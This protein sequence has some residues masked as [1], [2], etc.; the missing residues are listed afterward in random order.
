MAEWDADVQIDASV[1]AGLIEAQFPELS[2][3]TLV[4]F[5]SGWDNAAWLVNDRWVFRFPR[6]RLGAEVMAV[7]LAHL[8][9]LAP[10]LPLPAPLPVFIGS[11]ASGYPYPFGGYERLEG[12]TADAAALTDANRCA[13][14]A[15][16][17][18]FLRELHGLHVSARERQTVPGDLLRRA[19]PG[20][21]APRVL[22]RLAQLEGHA[23]VESG[24]IQDWIERLRTTPMRTEPPT[25]VHGD[26]YA[27]HLLVDRSARLCGIID[28]G[29]VH[30]GD[31][32]IDLSV[33]FSFVPPQGRDAF[34]GAYGAIDAASW[35][36]ARFRAL[37]YGVL[38]TG[39]GV[40]TD[41]VA[42]SAVG[43]TALRFATA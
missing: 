41:D 2:P 12:V 40:S 19:D 11:P 16:L 7:E 3:V 38:L 43:V 26:L 37:H 25:W 17:G 33:A 31:P 29:D 15:E 39:Y 8:P 42:L 36:R 24:R 35:D 34:R 5:G 20:Y 21:R 30:Q 13:L 27:R 4:P 18:A 23:G 22:E 32:A 10:R 1:A 9:S 14:A 6:R 28:W